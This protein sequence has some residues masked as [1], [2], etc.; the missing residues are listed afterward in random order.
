[1]EIVGQLESPETFFGHVKQP[2]SIVIVLPMDLGYGRKKELP[3]GRGFEV[4]F[5]RFAVRDLQGRP[6]NMASV[7]LQSR[8]LKRSGG[9]PRLEFIDPP[10]RSQTPLPFQTARKVFWTLPFGSPLPRA[11]ADQVLFRVHQAARDLT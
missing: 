11:P 8:R 9:I 3:D 6:R 10:A 2:C 1:M 4:E 5:S 7:R